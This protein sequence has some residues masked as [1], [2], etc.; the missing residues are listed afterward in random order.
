MSKVVTTNICGTGHLLDV[1]GG[2]GLSESEISNFEKLIM[3]EIFAQPFSICRDVSVYKSNYG[4]SYCLV[5]KF[6]NIGTTTV[7]FKRGNFNLLAAH[8]IAKIDKTLQL[9]H[10][11]ILAVE[12]KNCANLPW[13]TV[14]TV[15][16]MSFRTTNFCG[17]IKLHLVPENI[18]NKLSLPS[19]YNSQLLQLSGVR[20]EYEFERS[21]NLLI[22]PNDRICITLTSRGTF[23]LVGAKNETEM[24]FYLMQTYKIV[25]T[26]LQTKHILFDL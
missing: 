15:Q 20:V 5:M 17:S 3:V 16:L 2:C 7:I 24:N 10:Q 22:Y 14:A 19:L 13:S 6:A 1:K 9:L 11:L 8:N 18:S 21:P 4:N 25:K 12:L 23:Y 26:F